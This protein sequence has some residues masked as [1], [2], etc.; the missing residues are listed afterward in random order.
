M[1]F[2]SKIR[3]RIKSLKSFMLEKP[4]K[5][6][7]QAKAKIAFYRMRSKA[8]SNGFMTNDEIENEIIE[9]RK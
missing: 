4:D 2:K 8:S 9:T 3:K 6:I 5:Y 1:K 7:R